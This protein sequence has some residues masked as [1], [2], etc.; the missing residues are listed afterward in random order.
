MIP[1]EAPS[2]GAAR[3][4]AL[5]GLRILGVLILMAQLAAERLSAQV[6]QILNYQGRVVV[7]GTNFTGL[8]E[9]KFALVDSA[10]S[11]TFWSNDGT[12]LGGS[13]P[14]KAVPVAVA[15][16]LYS[17]G[18]GDTLL[19]NMRSLPADVFET[20]DVRLRVWFNDGVHGFQRLTPDQRVASVGYALQAQSVPDGSITA[21]KLAPGLMTAGGL[22]SQVTTLSNRLSALEARVSQLESSVPNLNSQVNGF[23]TRLST[24]ETQVNQLETSVPDLNSQVSDFSSR[25]DQD[26]ATLNQVAGGVAAA[27]LTAASTDPQD[28]RLIASGFTLF[29][30]L[31]A[32][33]WETSTASGA[34]SP[35]LRS[36]WVWTGNALLVWGGALVSG[37]DAASGAAYRPDLDQW[38]PISTLN[39][40]TGRERHS[41][42][43]SG[44]E[45]M[46]WG[47]IASGA[48]LN[49]GSRYNP[50]SQAW[51][52]ISTNGAPSPR[53]GQVAV[54]TGQR[55]F[56]WGGQDE[57]GLLGDGALY[58]PATD[59]W[60]PLNLPNAPSPR[61]GA[62]AVWA[63]GRLILWGGQ[64]EHGPLNT[65][66]ELLFD[67]SGQPTTWVS[68]S[69]VN[70]PSPRTGQ[71][72]VWTG[73]KL[74][75]WGGIGSGGL[76]GGG[77]AYYP[78]ANLW[79][80]ISSTGAPSARRD[81]AGIWSGS[82][83]LIFGGETA[84]GTANDGAAYDPVANTWRPLSGAGNPQARSAAA[85]V[86]SGTELIVFGGV[87]NGTT[88]SSLQRLNPQ[89]TWY[90]YRKQ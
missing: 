38:Q 54:W 5:R 42:V 23:S 3:T 83:M 69:L 85:A 89:P 22:D 74:L 60:T 30:S 80:A 65:G 33:A 28:P 43:W 6:P 81:Q 39:A 26:E 66:A 20:S 4:S 59:Q 19:T 32:P 44:S 84:G 61:T 48:Y 13:E 72:E 10:G 2:R 7:D 88:L 45:M 76:L 46:V 21:Q 68:T 71:A 67:G 11:T 17:A 8:G 34:P 75:I 50:G 27:G 55:M 77:A 12:S 9:F 90:L 62:V 18:L 31:A 24:V 51:S 58:D 1:F 79:S 82:E 40:P 41:V 47:G 16:G 35:S 25:L 29:T 15:K 56:I 78:L 87:S 57:N 53:A 14:A 49:T 70:A 73:Q 63:G 64:D 36:A 37:G 52:A 86:W